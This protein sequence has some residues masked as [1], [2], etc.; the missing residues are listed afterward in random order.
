MFFCKLWVDV[1]RR[2]REDPA[3]YEEC[4]TVYLCGKE[5]SLENLQDLF[6]YLDSHDPDFSKFRKQKK[7]K[8]K[9]KKLNE[10]IER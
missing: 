3:Y 4:E 6:E 9:L 10:N 5:V 8:E 1:L 7:V 2:A